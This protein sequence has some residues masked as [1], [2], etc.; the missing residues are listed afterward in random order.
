MFD[1]EQV[2]SKLTQEQKIALTSG[3]TFCQDT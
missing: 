3:T 1:V 2:L